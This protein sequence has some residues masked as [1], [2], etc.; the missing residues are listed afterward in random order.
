MTNDNCGR[1]RSALSELAG[2][3]AESAGTEAVS[4][5]QS[6]MKMISFG[7][8]LFELWHV[9]YHQHLEA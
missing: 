3:A 2:L 5:Q 7:F 8:L 9:P 4:C 6:M 1:R